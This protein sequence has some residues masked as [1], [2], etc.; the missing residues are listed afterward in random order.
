MLFAVGEQRRGHLHRLG[1]E[2]VIGAHGRLGAG[3]AGLD[4]E[5]VDEGVLVLRSPS[6]ARVVVVEADL[7]EGFSFSVEVDFDGLR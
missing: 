3:A 4:V 7:G 5:A 2:R 1:F 6:P